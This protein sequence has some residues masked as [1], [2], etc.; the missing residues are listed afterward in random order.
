M[1]SRDKKLQVVEV[2]PLL[3]GEDKP[4]RIQL[5]PGKNPDA[6]KLN[7]P[8]QVKSE[9]GRIYRAVL[10]GRVNP[11]VGDRLVRGLLLPIL[12]ATEIEQAFNLALDDPD[13]DRPVLAGLT[14][15]G[16]DVTPPKGAPVRKIERQ[17]APMAAEEREG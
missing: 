12:K 9:M 14:I 1:K 13:D 16:P 8:G 6:I 7:T 15:T 3:P 11:D 5:V 17:D 4:V 10:K 2:L